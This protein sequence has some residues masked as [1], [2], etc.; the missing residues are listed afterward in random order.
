MSSNLDTGMLDIESHGILLDFTE[1]HSIPYI[2]R[3]FDHP[4][5]QELYKNIFI[6]TGPHSPSRAPSPVLIGWRFF[7][8]AY[9]VLLNPDLS[10]LAGLC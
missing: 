10:S 3:L 5:G 1:D 6:L 9:L 4:T 7:D 8:V 2:Y